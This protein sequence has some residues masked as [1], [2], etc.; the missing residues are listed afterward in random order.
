MKDYY[1]PIVRDIVF[2]VSQWLRGCDYREKLLEARLNK[3]LDRQQIQELQFKK[4]GDL[5]MHA[6]AHVPY[7]RD[8]FFRMGITPA[9]IR[10]WD[11]YKSLPILTKADVRKHFEQFISEKPHS[12]VRKYRTSGSTGEPLN[13][14]TSEKAIAGEYACRLRAYE[15]W[16]I[17]F[18]DRVVYIRGEDRYSFQPN[19]QNWLNK[20]VYIPLKERF[21]NRRVLTVD[22]LEKSTLQKQWRIIRKFQPAYLHVF[23]SNLYYLAR[24]IKDSGEDAHS[25]KL[26]LILTGSEILFDYQKETLQEVFN[27]PVAENYGSFEIGIAANTYV[28]GAMHTNDDFVIL[29]VIKSNP[30]DEFGEIVGTRLDNWEF[31]LIR[32]NME[33]LAPALTEHQGCSLGLNFLKIDSI[34]GRKYGS[35]LLPDGQLLHG[36]YFFNLFRRTPGVR[37]FQVHQRQLDRY[38]ILIVLDPGS[39]FETAQSNIRERMIANIGAVSVNVSQVPT[40]QPGPGGKFHVVRTDLTIPLA[41]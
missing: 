27:C 31:P 23:P 32:Y 12:P 26:K 41:G 13:L 29:E 5:L 4:L 33:D 18:G 9:D 34:I 22:S 8:L 3:S 11:D 16:G 30:Q 25:L 24:M 37:Q 14:L 17:H 6:Y 36:N 10:T 40:I 35:V 20:Y 38:E 1:A 39:N 7:Y 19:L 2:P 28:C 15:S 21:F